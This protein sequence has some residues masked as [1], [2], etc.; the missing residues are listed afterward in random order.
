MLHENDGKGKS[1]Q[2]VKKESERNE[3]YAVKK[4]EI[5]DSESTQDERIQCIEG[6]QPQQYIVCGN[7]NQS[8]CQRR[9]QFALIVINHFVA[10]SD[11]FPIYLSYIKFAKNAVAKTKSM[12]IASVIFVSIKSEYS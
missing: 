6:Y 8:D 11:T 5:L 3:D 9:C 12:N 10:P 1:K 7:C 2:A 4:M